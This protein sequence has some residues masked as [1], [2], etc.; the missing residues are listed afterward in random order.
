MKDYYHWNEK[1]IKIDSCKSYGHPKVRDIWWCSVGLNIGTEIYGKGEDFARPVLV[2]HAEAG[3]SFI[4]IPLTSKIR[5]G[6]YCRVVHVNEGKLSTA[7][8]YQMRNFDKRRLKRKIGRISE[9]EY[10]GV[11]SCILNLYKVK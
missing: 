7:L 6:K 8:I 9:E 2:I 11:V 3:D 10:K 4:G 1:K 5:N